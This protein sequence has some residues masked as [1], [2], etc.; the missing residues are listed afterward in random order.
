[1]DLVQVFKK[2]EWSYGIQK[3][4]HRDTSHVIYFDIPNCEQISWHVELEKNDKVPEYTKE[5][6]KKENS[7]L[8]KLEKFAKIYLLSDS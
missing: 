4:S 2:N 5:W 6:D 8:G 1:M 7:T 3:I